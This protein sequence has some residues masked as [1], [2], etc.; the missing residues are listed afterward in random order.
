MPALNGAALDEDELDDEP[1]LD[2]EEEEEEE[3][4]DEDELDDEL[5][6]ELE[7]DDDELELDESD[8]EELELLLEGAVSASVNVAR[9][10]GLTAP[11]DAGGLYSRT[12]TARLPPFK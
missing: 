8:D 2:D 12:T 10:S 5:E 7:D 6:L 3:E 4:L 9:P 1:P 11:S